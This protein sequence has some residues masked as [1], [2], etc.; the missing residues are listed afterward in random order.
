MGKIPK[1]KHSNTQSQCSV[2]TFLH[3]P[4]VHRRLKKIHWE[5]EY[6]NTLKDFWEITGL[7]TV[8]PFL[9]SLQ[10]KHITYWCKTFIHI[11]WCE[12]IFAY[13]C[14][15]KIY[16]NL[17]MHF[18][19]FFMH[20]QNHTWFSFTSVFNAHTKYYKIYFCTAVLTSSGSSFRCCEHITFTSRVPYKK[21]WST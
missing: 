3:D 11:Y 15:N 18:T 13:C 6:F 16:T 10:W 1:T 19:I 7:T 20:L 21:Q 2:S 4:F 5:T 17:Q 12:T 9:H 8:N 14:K